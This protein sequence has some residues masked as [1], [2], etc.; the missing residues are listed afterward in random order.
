[1][2]TLTGAGSAFTAGAG[3]VFST[4]A[5]GAL[6]IGIGSAIAGDKKVFGASGTMSSAIGAGIGAG[7]GAFFGSP[8]LGAAIGGA[9]GGVVNKLFGKGPLEKQEARLLGDVNALGFEGVVNTRFKA[10]G[11]VFGKGKTDN[12]I[13]DTD[14][15]DLLNSFKG[16]RESGIS[17]KLLPFVDEAREQI[18][19]IGKILDTTIQGFN[20]NLTRHSRSAWDSVHSHLTDSRA[21]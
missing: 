8:A 17:S 14:S 7:A 19:E 6:G 4:A 10:D 1:M 12:V 20:Q 2:P 3:T 5:A 15:G 9:L 18:L 21:A 13:L 11:S 16:L